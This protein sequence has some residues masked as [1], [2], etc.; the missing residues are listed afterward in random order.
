VVKGV[1]SES[2]LALCLLL[3]NQMS[4]AINARKPIP[5]KTPPIIGPTVKGGFDDIPLEAECSPEVVECDATAAPAVDVC[6]VC[7]ALGR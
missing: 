2:L 4:N 6:E 3:K 5:P 7:D 1:S